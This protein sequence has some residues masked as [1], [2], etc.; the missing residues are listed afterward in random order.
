M[1]GIGR[2]YIEELA[3]TVANLLALEEHVVDLPEFRA[4][5]YPRVRLWREHYV[6]KLMEAVNNPNFGRDWCVVKHLL[7]AA[8]HSLECASFIIRADPERAGEAKGYLALA[9]QLFDLAVEVATGG[10]RKE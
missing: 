7:L 8:V 10:G 5:L 6:L 4:D 3:W 1:I 9:K 2:G